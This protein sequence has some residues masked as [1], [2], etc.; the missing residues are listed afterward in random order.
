MRLL[1]RLQ[2]DAFVIFTSIVKSK[3]GVYRKGLTRISNEIKNH[4]NKYFT[5]CYD[6][7]DIDASTYVNP[8]KEYLLHCYENKTTARDKLKADITL[9]QADRVRHTCLYCLIGSPDTFDHYLPK[10]LYPE[11]AV[12]SINLM[13]CC[14]KCNGK[15]GTYWLE[16][17]KRKIVNL[18]FEHIPSGRY[19]YAK[20]DYFG[21]IP[22]AD[23]SLKTFAEMSDE[24]FDIIS[25]HFTKL[26]LLQRFTEK[27]TE[28][29]SEAKTH[30]DFHF[31]KATS[32]IVQEY[33][34]K[35]S[36]HLSETVQE[37]YW[38]A[39]LYEALSK[40]TEFIDRCINA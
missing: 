14:S 8:E 33:F 20:V 10:E 39:V 4:Y 12:N 30:I 35:E 24:T 28:V 32:E 15:K 5:C 18:Y 9:A 16:D 23:F 38:K 2:Q 21:D 7:V 13:P 3:R 36:R 26:E 37:N 31:P 19:L 17:G 11:Y 22:R 34:M 6:L 29:F 25:A 40:N 1:N 27:S